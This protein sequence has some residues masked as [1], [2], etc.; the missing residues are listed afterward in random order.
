M[1]LVQAVDFFV[2]IEACTL[3]VSE[4]CTLSPGKEVGVGCRFRAGYEL[5]QPAWA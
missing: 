1:R 4:A 5:E 2:V 3:S